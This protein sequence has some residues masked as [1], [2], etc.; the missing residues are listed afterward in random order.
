MSTIIATLKYK[1]KQYTV[2]MDWGPSKDRTEEEDEHLAYYMW[3]DGNYSCDCNRL[4]FIS[5]EYEDFPD[6]EDENGHID[7]GETVKLVS[8]T[9]DGKDLLAPTAN[10]RLAAIGLFSYGGL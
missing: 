6:P 3:T 1:G 5:D 9:L 10:E 4:A 2:H 8:L 7:C